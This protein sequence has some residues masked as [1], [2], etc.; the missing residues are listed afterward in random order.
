MFVRREKGKKYGNKTV[1]HEGEKYDSKKELNRFL[2]L[3]D[4]ERRGLISDLKRQVKF[5]LIPAIKEQQIVHLKTKDKII[6]R[7][8][9]LAIS[10]TCDFS[11]MKDGQLVIEDVKASPQMLPKEFQLKFKMMRYFHGITVRLVYKANEDI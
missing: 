6:E 7:T 4:A 3:R 2:F 8:V 5:E 1:L 9:Q 10:Y 11:Y